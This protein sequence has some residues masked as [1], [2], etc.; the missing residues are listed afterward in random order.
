MDLA[1]LMDHTG[2]EEDS[3]GER[4]FPGIDMRRNPNIPG[5]FQRNF[6]VWGIVIGRSHFGLKK[7]GRKFLSF[8]IWG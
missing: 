5:S 2:V 1:Q 7:W 8:R 6:P 4:C 3:L